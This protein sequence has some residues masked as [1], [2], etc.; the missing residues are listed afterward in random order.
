MTLSEGKVVLAMNV[1]DRIQ[2]LRKL[3]GL[4]QEELA[5]KIGVS[6]QAVSKWENEQSLPDLEKIILLSEYFNVS[7]DYLLRGID[8]TQN[9]SGIKADARIFAAIGTGLNFIGLVIAILIWV[10][11]RTVAAVAAGLVI[12]AMGSMIF[13]IGQ[14]LADNKKA[15]VNT[16]IFINIWFLSL[17]PISCIFNFIQGTLGGFWWTLTPIPQR[18]NSLMAYLLCWLVYFMVCLI[19][20]VILVVKRR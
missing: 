16:F 3:K 5:D 9:P 2:N 6:R 20:D 15:A 8:T 10:D 4:S 13:V 12:M 14:F 7:T 17:I 1:A 18:G 19:V 11:K